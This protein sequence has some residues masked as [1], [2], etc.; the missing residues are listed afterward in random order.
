MARKSI[1]TVVDEVKQEV[2]PA[3]KF[4]LNKITYIP[5]NKAEKNQT[6]EIVEPKEIIEQD[7][8]K[9]IKVVVK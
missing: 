6:V 5:A 2:L 9:F 3:K 8:V 1:K 4:D 7:G